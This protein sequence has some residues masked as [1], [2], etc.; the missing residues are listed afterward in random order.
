MGE[1]KRM[2]YMINVT[3]FDDLT[4]KNFCPCS[5]GAIAKGE[6]DSDP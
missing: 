1:E 4:K 6:I 5:Y 2:R 3:S